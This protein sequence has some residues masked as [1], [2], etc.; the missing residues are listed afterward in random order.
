M[1]TVGHSRLTRPLPPRVPFPTDKLI[2]A[3]SGGRANTAEE[4]TRAF[5]AL[6]LSGGCRPCRLRK[7]LKPSP[8]IVISNLQSTV[9]GTS[10]DVCGRGP[11]LTLTQF[12]FDFAVKGGID[13]RTNAAVHRLL[14]SSGAEG[15]VLGPIAACS[16]GPCA[17]T[18]RACITA[19]NSHTAG[20]IEVSATEPYRPSR[21]GSSKSVTTARRASGAI[22]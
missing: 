4:A 21:R 20:T 8:A 11:G 12:T 10:L 14:S 19:G 2:G 16:S 22:R 1:D 15:E 13:I 9:L 17:A 18:P 6:G 5:R 7:P 3:E